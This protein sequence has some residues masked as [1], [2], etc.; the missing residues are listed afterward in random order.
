MGS[1]YSLMLGTD[2]TTHTHTHTHTQSM[3]VLILFLSQIP[4]IC[5]IGSSGADG[6]PPVRDRHANVPWIQLYKERLLSSSLF[7]HPHSPQKINP[8]LISAEG[9]K[10]E[11]RQFN[12]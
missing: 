4:A 9:A 6:K 3:Y 8:L 2:G 1:D 11:N 7:L 10:M 12:Y 5:I